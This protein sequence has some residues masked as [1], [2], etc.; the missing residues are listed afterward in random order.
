MAQSI[1]K[2]EE[3][4]IYLNQSCN[5]DDDI[6]QGRPGVS[7]TVKTT[8]FSDIMWNTRQ[9][10]HTWQT[11]GPFLHSAKPIYWFGQK[12]LPWTFTFTCY[13][14]AL[15]CSMKISQ[16]KKW[17]VHTY[18]YFRVLESL[19]LKYSKV[20]ENWG[21]SAQRSVWTKSVLSHPAVPD[22]QVGLKNL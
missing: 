5:P 16:H 18:M 21:W 4:A 7:D 9:N 13:G 19:R 11:N 2:L 1:W 17:S 6:E 22:T 15:K 12:K 20:L 10:T 3:L 8:T 14:I